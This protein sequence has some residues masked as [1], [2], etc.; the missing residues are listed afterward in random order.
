M[1]CQGKELRMVKVLVQAQADFD[2]QGSLSRSAL[3]F[4]A[5]RCPQAV[6]RTLVQWGKDAAE[7]QRGGA[8]EARP[9]GE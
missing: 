8:D 2:A 4:A 3:H 7:G 6:V 9:V 5:S 1:A